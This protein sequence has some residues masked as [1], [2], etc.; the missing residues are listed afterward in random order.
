MKIVLAPDSFKESLSSFEVCNA[1]K[2]GLLKELPDIQVV[3]SP[4]ADGGEGTV[5]TLL[6]V[7]GAKSYSNK[8]MGPMGQE[9]RAKWGILSENANTAIIEMAS[10]S[11]LPLIPP[12]LR[13]P[14][15]T[16]SYGVGELISHA[17]DTG[18]RNILI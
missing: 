5:E 4:I 1:L 13:N 12:E 15:K 17:V 6:T 2:T 9:V 16:T 18:A 11:G 10:A 7:S 3:L 14:M 8:V